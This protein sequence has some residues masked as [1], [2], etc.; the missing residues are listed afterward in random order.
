MVLQSTLFGNLVK[1]LTP[2]PSPDEVATLRRL[3]NR[4]ET[5][6]WNY[7][8]MK[9][10]KKCPISSPITDTEWF[11][12]REAYYAN[13]VDPYNITERAVGVTGE[14]IDHLRWT[15]EKMLE[16]LDKPILD[17]S[18]FDDDSKRTVGE[19]RENQG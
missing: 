16:S 4:S 18:D 2:A 19:D 6:S 13:E 3:I 17:E 15:L 5:V 10:T 14:S 12:V 11:E 9:I 7:R 1:K 8:V